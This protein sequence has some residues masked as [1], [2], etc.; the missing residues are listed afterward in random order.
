[1]TSAALRP[2]LPP[3]PAYMK[4]LPVDERGYPVPHFVAW[5][6]GKPDHRVADPAKMVRAHKLGLCH[7][8]G[9]RLGSFKAFVVGPMCGINRISSDPPSH[10]E[11][12]EW[13]AVACPFLSRP[14]AHRRAAGLP[15][16]IE[17]AAGF[18]IQRNPG[19]TLVWVTK[20]YSVV[21]AEGGIGGLF[22]MGDPTAVLFFAEGRAATREEIDESVSSGLPLLLE[23][24]TEEGPQAVKALERM[25]DVF[26]SLLPRG[27]SPLSD[28]ASPSTSEGV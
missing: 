17:H 12:A 6:D 2:S 5:I 19:V 9:N 28:Q 15:E 21:K 20:S 16:G 10:R 14:K 1:M 25:T 11:C 18:A 3:L 7:L 22:R 26:R 23:P 13:A 27:V 24:A 4:N 8:C